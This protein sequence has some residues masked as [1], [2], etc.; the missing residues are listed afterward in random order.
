[1]PLNLN[2]VNRGTALKKAYN[3]QINEQWQVEIP[4]DLR[5]KLQLK[6]NDWVNISFL[7]DSRE[8]EEYYEPLL[9]D[10]AHDG[11]LIDIPLMNK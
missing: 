2:N 4:V 6:I 11:V 9:E 1:M 10:L 8:T 7:I 3:L 5:E